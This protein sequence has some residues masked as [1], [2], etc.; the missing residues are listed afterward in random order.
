MYYDRNFNSI[1]FLSTKTIYQI[2]IENEDRDVWKGHLEKGNFQ[3]ALDHCERNSLPQA[4]KVA[5]LY[6]NHLFENKEYLISAVL[7]GKSDEKFEEVALRFLM[8]QNYDALKGILII[9]ILLAYLQIIDG[10]FGHVDHTQR[11]L[12]ATW[13]VEIY[14]NELNNA[15]DSSNYKMIKD[16]LRDWLRV[17]LDCLDKVSKILK[18]QEYN[19]PATSAIRA[20]C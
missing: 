20:S 8:T 13:L 1:F 14:L 9:S 10:R 11:S 6:A 4:K 7:Y 3:L 17:K 18:F 5:R 16:S 19:L 15:H 12:I 2:T